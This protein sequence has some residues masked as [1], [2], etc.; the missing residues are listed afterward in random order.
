MKKIWSTL[1]LAALCQCATAQEH[2]LATEAAT[3]C[4]QGQ[5][6]Q[7]KAKVAEA[8]QSADENVQAYTW[9]VAGFVYKECY[10]TYESKM[11]ES[12]YREQSVEYLLKAFEMDKM[13]E[14][15]T[16]I[17]SSIKF[18]A[19]TYFN[20]A[21]MR[22]REF[23]ESTES[24]PEK[25][26]HQYRKLMRTIEPGCNLNAQDKDYHQQMGQRYFDLWLLNYDKDELADKALRE[27][28][29]ALRADSSDC[30]LQFN[31]GVLQYNRAVFLYRSIG[32]DTDMMDMMDLQIRASDLIKQKAMPA[33][34]TADAICPNHAEILNALLQMNKALERENDIEYFKEE[35]QRLIEE[36]KM[37]SLIKKGQP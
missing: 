12:Q 4:Q 10:K 17:K 19:S 3:L 28:G 23:D 14:H 37:R 6:E 5:L 21:L 24:E 15:G 32:P 9:F 18:L 34:R 36:G 2:A 27:F 1:I 7:A 22:T 13:R 35:I 30:M 33:M 8:L 25:Y 16:N 31:V 29:Q 20:D 11:R 26:F